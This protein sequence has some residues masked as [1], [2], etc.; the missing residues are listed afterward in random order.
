MFGFTDNIQTDFK[1]MRPNISIKGGEF[2]N[3]LNVYIFSRIS[4]AFSLLLL[5]QFTVSS[6][7]M[8]VLPNLNKSQRSIQ[9]YRVEHLQANTCVVF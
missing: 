2:I 3:H 8:A 1:E 4:A 7:C 6:N 5:R 9:N